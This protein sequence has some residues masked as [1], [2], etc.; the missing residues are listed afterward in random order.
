MILLILIAAVMLCNSIWMPNLDV[1]SASGTVVENMVFH[2][3]SLLSK[4]ENGSLFIYDGADAVGPRL[5]D[6]FKTAVTAQTEGTYSGF[7]Y[8][9]GALLWGIE[10]QKDVHVSGTVEIRA[11]ISSTF[12]DF[13]FLDG[14]GYGMG[15]AEIDTEGETLVQQFVTQGPQYWRQNPFTATP[16]VYTLTVNVDHVFKKGNYLG[17]FVGAG[18]T[19]QGFTFTVYFDS[20]NCNSGASLPIVDQTETFVFNPEWEGNTYEVVATSNS[21]L[22]DI[23]LDGS[24]KEITFDLWGIHGTSG[25]CQVSVPK[26]LLEGPFT[27]Y[28]GSQQIVPTVT[29]NATHSNIAFNYVHDSDRIR[30]IGTQLTPTPTPTPTHPTPTP[31]PTPTVQLTIGATVGGSTS[32]VVGN[33]TYVLYST[34]SATATADEGYE[35]DYWLLN[36]GSKD[37]HASISIYM[38]ESKTVLAVF[39]SVIPQPN[40]TPIPTPIPTATPTPTST[41][42]PITPTPT[43]T[44]TSPNYNPDFPVPELLLI[45]IIAS[46]A[47]AFFLVI[48][49]KKLK[50][51]TQSA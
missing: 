34:V 4:D 27:V 11:Y 42:T 26:T 31:T 45:A 39:K 12:S 46:A 50:S 3:Y 28:L 47:A 17:F 49:K 5:T 15:L 23:G 25:Y 21:A 14:A 1:N 24:S 7:A 44:G 2:Y 8:W 9:S 36:D 13:G 18:S 20:P 10:L 41:P 32:P 40:P 43:A 48:Y 35:F 29:E 19:V 33:Y 22:S 51:R 30:V 16:A 37:N 38:S 6:A